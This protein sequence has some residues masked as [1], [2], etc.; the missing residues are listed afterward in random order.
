MPKSQ[1]NKDFIPERKEK[2][3][4]WACWGNLKNFTSLAVLAQVEEGQVNCNLKSLL[5]KTGPVQRL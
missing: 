2:L 1:K 3:N 4:Y 5:D